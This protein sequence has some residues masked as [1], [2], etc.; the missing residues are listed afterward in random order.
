MEPGL[1]EQAA[2]MMWKAI[3]KGVSFKLAIR[4]VERRILEKA[5]GT[6]GGTRRELAS[7]LR[8]SERTLY[9]KMREQRRSD[10]AA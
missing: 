4:E 7:L 5:M 6:A 1:L 3:S 8:T 10:P 9:Y 2:G